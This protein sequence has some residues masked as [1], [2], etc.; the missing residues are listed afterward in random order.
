MCMISQTGDLV[1]AHRDV[2]FSFH[3]TLTEIT[4]QWYALR[5]QEVLLGKTC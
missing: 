3:F 4:E 1:A 2:K 5:K